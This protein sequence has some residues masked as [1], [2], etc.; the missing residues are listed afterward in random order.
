LASC[1]D[2]QLYRESVDCDAMDQNKLVEL[3]KLEAGMEDPL[4]EVLG[5]QKAC[6]LLPQTV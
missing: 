2:N 1:E 3:K 4:T 5:G 6:R